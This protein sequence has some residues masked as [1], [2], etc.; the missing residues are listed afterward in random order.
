M[1]VF[2]NRY[3]KLFAVNTQPTAYNEYRTINENIKT[4]NSKNIG[5]ILNDDSWEYPLFTD[6][7]KRELNPIHINVKNYTA[8]IAGYNNNVDCIVSTTTNAPFI[9]YKGKRFYNQNI[10]N[11]AIWYYKLRS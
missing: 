11:A 8:R 6:C 10:K 2:A 4:S 7:Y 1:P 3:I 9:D 5:L